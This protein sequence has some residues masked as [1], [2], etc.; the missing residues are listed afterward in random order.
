MALCVKPQ[1]REDIERYA[2]QCGRTQDLVIFGPEEPHKLNLLEFELNHGGGSPVSRL[3]N[4]V[5]L[6]RT[7]L[8]IAERDRRNNSSSG[9]NKYFERAALQMFRAALLPLIVAKEPVTWRT[10]TA[11]S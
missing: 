9:D 6:F 7:A 3:E 10:S 2:R 8:E 1:D 5:Q 4:V 11:S